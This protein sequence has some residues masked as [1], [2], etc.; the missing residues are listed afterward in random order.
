MLSPHNVA[1]AYRTAHE[2]RRMEGDGLPRASA[3]PGASVRKHH[4]CGAIQIDYVT[5]YLSN[6]FPIWRLLRP[7]VS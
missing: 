7:G 6:Y 2:A 4:E 1:D 5:A 3:V